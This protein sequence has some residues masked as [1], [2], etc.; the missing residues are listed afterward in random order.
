[1]RYHQQDFFVSD[2]RAEVL[3][4][5]FAQAC[6]NINPLTEIEQR[7]LGLLGTEIYVME[8]KLHQFTTVLCPPQDRA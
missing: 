5:N 3:L 7:L 1:M 2:C 4:E 6:I 8:M